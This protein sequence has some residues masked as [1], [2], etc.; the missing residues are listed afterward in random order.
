[1]EGVDAIGR[2]ALEAVRG[3]GSLYGF[4]VESVREAA[5][6]VRARHVPFRGELLF[7]QTARV[8]VGS[9][10]LV[11]LVSLFLGVTSALLVGYQ[12]RRL[13]AEE[14]VP[15]F[16]AVS[17]TRELGAL[18]TGIVVA[19]RSGAAFTAELGTMRVSEEIDAIE[20]MG[21][22]PLRYLVAP[23]VLAS[24]LMLPSLSVVSSLA[25]LAGGALVARLQ[26]DISVRYFFVLTMDSL[27]LRDVWAGLV[28]SLLFGGIIGLVACYKGISASRGA[29]GV[30]T[31]TTSSV[32]TSITGVL[33][34]DTLC[35]I[36]L[37]RFWE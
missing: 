12:L 2:R 19:A 25:A 15:G 29:I 10:P 16:V 24:L 28:K 21:I 8:G 4:A 32:V 5:W 36:L 31:A 9:V 22:G 7:E 13:G 35:N 17:F 33:A 34:C 11:A 23:R 18:L 6:R 30:G 26:F 27:V 37:V 14:Q 20:G 3:L 1:L